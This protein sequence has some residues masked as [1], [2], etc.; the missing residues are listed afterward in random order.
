MP[1]EGDIAVDFRRCRERLEVARGERRY[2]LRRR[3]VVVDADGL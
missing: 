3:L 2:R 1:D